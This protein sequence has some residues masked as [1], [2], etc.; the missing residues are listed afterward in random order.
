[1]PIRSWGEGHVPEARALSKNI[2]GYRDGGGRKGE[3][4]RREREI[5]GEAGRNKTS[6]ILQ[7]PHG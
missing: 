3:N 1:M 7:G 6:L 5:E 2:Q 4:G